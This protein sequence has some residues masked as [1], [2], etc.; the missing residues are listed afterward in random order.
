[1]SLLNSKGVATAVRQIPVF[2]QSGEGAAQCGGIDFRTREKCPA[3]L[4][5]VCEASVHTLF[6]TIDSAG[7]QGNQVVAYIHGIVPR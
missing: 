3:I 1:V 5:Q 4:L 6:N 7:E 2:P